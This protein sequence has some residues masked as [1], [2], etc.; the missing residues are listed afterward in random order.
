MYRLAGPLSYGLYAA[1]I[2]DVNLTW[3]GDTDYTHRYHLL[4]DLYARHRALLRRGRLLRRHADD[5]GAVGW[6]ETGRA[7]LVA[8]L[9]YAAGRPARM[10]ADLSGWR[11]PQRPDLQPRTPGAG[12]NWVAM[13]MGLI[14]ISM[15]C[16]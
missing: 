12:P 1:N 7:V 2:S 6:R 4:E 8:A 3:V 5:D 9:N 15:A 10:Y 13:D 16:G 11:G 14:S